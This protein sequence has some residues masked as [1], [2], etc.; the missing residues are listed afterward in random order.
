MLIDT[1]G[2]KTLTQYCKYPLGKTPLHFQSRKIY[3]SNYA[4]SSYSAKLC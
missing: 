3:S 4:K 1:K 2:G